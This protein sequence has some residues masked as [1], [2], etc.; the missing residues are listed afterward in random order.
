M[1]DDIKN[2]NKIYNYNNKQEDNFKEN[3]KNF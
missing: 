2:N 1:V 3:R